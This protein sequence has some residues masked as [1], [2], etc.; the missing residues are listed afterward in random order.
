MNHESDT[1][2]REPNRPA[3]LIADDDQTT[4]ILMRAMFERLGCSVDT[5]G[6]GR[7]AVQ[8]ALS[9]RYDLILMDVTMPCMPGDEAVRRIRHDEQRRGCRRTPIVALSGHAQPEAR[10]ALRAAGVDDY[11]AKP[12]QRVLLE[13]LLDRYRDGPGHQSCAGG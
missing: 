1:A 12:V 5:V 6:D 13:A 10:E 8:A 11:M 9:S 4:Q 7:A 3:I 2:A